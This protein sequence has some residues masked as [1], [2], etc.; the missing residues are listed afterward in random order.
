MSNRKDRLALLLGTQTQFL[1]LQSS[2]YIFTYVVKVSQFIR[3]QTPTRHPEEDKKTSKPNQ[4][5]V[6]FL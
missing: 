2:F 3:Q 4:M 1:I 5:Q 6:K